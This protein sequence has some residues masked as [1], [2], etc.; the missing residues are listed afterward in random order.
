MK[1]ESNSS[2][3]QL[4]R[5]VE[6][7]F[8][9][10]EGMNEDFR[11]YMECWAERDHLTYEE[12]K[13]AFSLLMS[14]DVHDYQIGQFLVYATPEF[15]SA[16]EIAGF[17]SI[18]RDSANKVKVA[19]AEMLEDTCGTGGDTIPTYNIST[20]IM[21]ILAAAK[22][23]I[24]K[25]GNR[26]V[27]SRCG[28]ADVLEELG[29]NTG[30]NAEQVGECI[31]DIGIG[32]MFA[33]NFHPAT[34]KVQGIRKKLAKLAD[35]L[36]DVVKFKT[37]FNVLGPL[38]NPARVKRQIMGVYDKSFLKKLAQVF[39]KLEL[40]RA[41][42][43]HG[44]CDRSDEYKGLD[45]V[46]TLGQT[47]IAELKDGKIRTYIITPRQM[48]LQCAKPEDV[49]G[50]EKAD[51]AKIIKAILAGEERGPKRDIALANAAVG[52]YVG[53]S[54]NG[55]SLESSLQ[56]HIKRAEKLID[57]GAAN[58]KLQQLIETSQKLGKK[59]AE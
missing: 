48:G 15:L 16:D 10:D 6:N 12:A 17:A 55:D 38:S 44:C 7:R 56:D 3:L 13:D 45:E 29:V 53:L 4:Q 31:D 8:S 47:H 43:V 5:F 33:P 50:G 52:L 25:H 41:V 23:K 26:A 24:A 11:S 35:E 18:L 36:P 20:T 39:Q 9:K 59:L 30:L 2:V 46:S 32:F 54:T 42:I 21:F 57:S 37:V 34:R 22:I 40:D 51:N 19:D 1:E 14:S 27:T 28:S 49:A 58:Q